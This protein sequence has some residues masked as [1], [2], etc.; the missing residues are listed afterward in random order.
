M[1][2]VQWLNSI[3]MQSTE[4]PL[5]AAF[6]MGVLVAINPCQLS[7]SI[8]ALTFLTR[9]NGEHFLRNGIAYVCGRTVAYTMLGVVIMLVAHYASNSLLSNSFISAVPIWV[10]W[11]LPYFFFLLGLFFLVRSLWQHAHHD[12]S[13]HNSGITIRTYSRL[14]TFLLGCILVFLFCPE[15]AALYFGVVTPMSLSS[16]SGWLLFL[17]FAI[18]AGVPILL[19]LFLFNSMWRHVILQEKHLS[20]V[21]KWINVFMGA[22]FILLSLLLFFL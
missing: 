21:Q 5:L 14:G 3:F 9:N 7:I 11:L 13:C 18:G 16:S 19:L 2:I 22:V 8:S 10:E 17:S 12:E 1:T 20:L 6:V 4:F 15:S